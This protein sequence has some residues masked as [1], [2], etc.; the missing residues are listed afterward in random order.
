MIFCIVIILVSKNQAYYCKYHNK[1]N[2]GNMNPNTAR[3]ISLDEAVS[4]G[5]GACGNCYR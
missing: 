2:C 1:S 3:Y 4:L 5:Y